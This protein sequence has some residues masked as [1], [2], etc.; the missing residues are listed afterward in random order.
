MPIDPSGPVVPDPKRADGLSY[1]DPELVPFWWD[2]SAL[3][4]WQLVPLTVAT[5]DRHR[6]WDSK[7]FAL[8]KVVRDATGG[9]VDLMVQLAADLHPMV[10]AGLLEEVHTCTWRNGHAMLSTAQAYRPGAAGFQHHVWQ[11]TLDERAVVFTTHP[12]NR[13]SR[14]AGD[15]LDHDR[16][17]TGSATLPLSVQHRRVAIHRYQPAFARPTERSLAAFAYQRYTHAYFPTECFDE[18]RSV[19][20]WTLGRRRH[21]FVALWSWRAPAWRHHDPAEVFTNGL[22]EPFDLVADGGADDVWI[23]EVGDADRW[24]SFDDFCSA[25]T[26][27]DVEVDDPGWAGDGPHPGF[28][29]TYASPSEGLVESSPDSW[30]RVDGREVSVRGADRFRN[31][32]TVVARGETT[33]PIRDDHGAWLLDL[34]AGRR[35]PP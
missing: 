18:V 21:G 7:L 32:F 13:P 11:A 17:W 9:D 31:P 1:T 22:T 3:T 30:L 35:G 34:S 19:G 20:H 6:L 16:Y 27:A 25:V 26:G 5:L 2:R 29:V 14:R 15:W 33:I 28:T 8:F 12:G 24:G 23:C 4:P 10:N